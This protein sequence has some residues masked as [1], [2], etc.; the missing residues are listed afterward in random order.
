MFILHFLFLLVLL[1]HRHLN[2]LMY[3]SSVSTNSKNAV[4]TIIK[5][6][7]IIVFLLLLSSS[8]I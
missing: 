2:I 4:L 6:I 5:L 3:S 8:L 7:M 1:F